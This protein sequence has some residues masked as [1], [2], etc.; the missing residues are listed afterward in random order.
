VSKSDA[1]VTRVHACCN[2]IS[3]LQKNRYLE[4]D[5]QS[6][7]YQTAIGILASMNDYGHLT[8][9]D[10]EFDVSGETDQVRSFT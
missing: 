2:V 7:R 4:S 1:Q 8:S 9:C 3:S 5:A 10:P 6:F